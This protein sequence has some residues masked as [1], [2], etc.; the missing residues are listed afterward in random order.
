MN[1]LLPVLTSQ[2]VWGILTRFVVDIFFLTLLIHVIYLRYSKKE[3]F[4]FTFYLI[5]IMVFFLSTIMNFV[6][7]SIT[8]GVGLFAI[9]AVLRFRTTNF[10]VKDMAYIFAAIGISVLNAIILRPLV[11]E[12]RLVM[13]ILIILSTFILEEIARKNT[14]R[15]HRITFENLELLR[16]ENQQKLLEEISARSGRNILRVKILKVDYKKETADLDIFFKV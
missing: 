14:Y 16:P 4:M 5:G 7:F 3:K 15:S 13:N 10:G 6:S 8:F 2:T 11:F 12:S 1:D 9:F